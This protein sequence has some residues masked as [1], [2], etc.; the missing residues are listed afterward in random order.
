MYGDTLSSDGGVLFRRESEAHVG[1]MRR[2][3]EVFKD[4]RDPRF[5]DHSYENMLSQRIFQIACG[6]EDANACD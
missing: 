2:F 1:G 4:P 3:V 6:D 5:I